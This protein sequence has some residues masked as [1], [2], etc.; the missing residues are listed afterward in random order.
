[1]SSAISR[2]HSPSRPTAGSSRTS[3]ETRSG[4]D[5]A[6]V[7]ATAPPNEC[8]TTTAGASSSSASAATLA[9]IVHGAA[10]DERPWPEQVRCGDREFGQMPRGQ[11]LPPLPVPGEPVN[12]QD[13]GAP[14]RAEPVKV[15]VFAHASDAASQS[16]RPNV[17]PPWCHSGMSA[18]HIDLTP[19]AL[20]EPG[21]RGVVRL[22]GGAGTGKSTLLI[23]AAAAH[24][25]AGTDPESVLLLTGSA[26][27]GTRG[28]GRHHVGTSGS[29]YARGRPR[30][31]G[32]HGALVRIRGVASGRAAQGRSAAAADHQRRAGRHHPRTARRRPRRR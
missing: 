7:N 23:Q 12:G 30:T 15:Q 9:S 8:P 10:H 25:A 26:R 3:A 20:T 18:P 5:A 19:T 16:A 31:P 29:G 4:R 22:I 6:R 21:L 28:A 1:M 17:G 32:A 14:R 24:I 2:I 11:R 27:L 13:L